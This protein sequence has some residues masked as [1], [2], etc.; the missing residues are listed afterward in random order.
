MNSYTNIEAERLLKA[1][2]V[3]RILNISRSLAYRLIQKS[4]I[5]FV[6]IGKACRVRPQDLDTYIER[7]LHSQAEN[8]DLHQ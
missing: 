4:E 3:A 6:R 7:N 2:D 8:L 5:P 1:L